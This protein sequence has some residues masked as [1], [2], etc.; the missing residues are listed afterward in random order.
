MNSPEGGRPLGAR[1]HLAAV[2]DL[3][4]PVHCLAC[5]ASGQAWCTRCRQPAAPVAIEVRGVTVPVVTAARYDGPLRRAVLAY[6][7][8][9]Q[10]GLAAALAPYLAAAVRG[11]EAEVAPLPSAVPSAVLVPMPSRRASARAR[12]GAH[13]PRLCRRE[14]LRAWQ[15]A[16]RT[17]R[18]ASRVLDSTTLTA[19]QRASNLVGAMAARA[20][21]PRGRACVLVDDVV[22]T[23][24]SVREACRALEESGWLV[25]GAA[26]IAH[27]P[28]RR[29]VAG[30]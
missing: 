19:E 24:A 5:G 15:G 13:L 23:G 12:G 8:D 29:D 22:T 27:V 17:L 10:R 3:A 21:V 18:L 25:F 9:N 16:P 2:L 14:P 26:A 28:L 11:L 20:A 1:R 30:R 6:K 7:E 4:L